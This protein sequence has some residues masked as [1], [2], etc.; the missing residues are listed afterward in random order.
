MLINN[1]EG[2][3]IKQSKLA[4]VAFIVKNLIET[5][6]NLVVNVFDLVVLVSSLAKL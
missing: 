4:E 1:L 5:S 3:L 2:L 6:L